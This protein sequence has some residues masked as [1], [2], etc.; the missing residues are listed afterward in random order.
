MVNQGF[1]PHSV[2]VIS[3]P[4]ASINVRLDS[5]ALQD[6]LAGGVMGALTGALVGAGL[7]ASVGVELGNAVGKGLGALDGHSVSM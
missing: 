5:L 6:D 3:Q 1:P 4:M 2:G 7:G